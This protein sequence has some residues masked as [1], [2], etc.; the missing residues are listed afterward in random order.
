MVLALGLGDVIGDVTETLRVPQGEINS[1]GCKFAPD[2]PTTD[3]T[4][5]AVASDDV[6]AFTVQG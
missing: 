5:R 4:T 1:D 3:D 6:M 2:G